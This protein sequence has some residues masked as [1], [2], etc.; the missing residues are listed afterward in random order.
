MDILSAIALGVLQGLTEFLPV[1]SSGHLVLAQE[2]LAIDERDALPLD[3]CLHFGTLVAVLIY[4]RADL[5]IIVR[6]VAGAEVADGDRYLKNWAWLLVAATLPIVG[7]VLWMGSAIEA[8]FS[9]PTA[10]GGGL[11]VS[12]AV[13]V[14]GT[15]LS[16]RG[17]R[18]P[19]SVGVLDALVVGA[20]QAMAIFPGVS[21]SGA[22]IVGGL[23]RG[24]RPEVAA[25]FA[26]LLSIPAILGAMVREAT[27][28]GEL[29]GRTPTAVLCGVVA[30]AVTGA[31]A[32]EVMMRAVR[33]GRL[34][35]FA[36]Y[37]GV[38]GLV[39]LAWGWWL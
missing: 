10:V 11:L 18:E 20:F 28:V 33:M 37:C 12:A 31:L 29:L 23:A 7:L 8:A 6:A 27:G 4:F 16:A 15:R 14:L 22:T 32:I 30:A 26:F 39:A 21:R 35:P 13:L 38:L 1:S 2:L 24:L 17:A 9:S 3:V 5:A 19:A 36:I 34:R 25:R